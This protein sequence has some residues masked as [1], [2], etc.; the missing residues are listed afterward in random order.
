MKSLLDKI[1]RVLGDLNLL[2]Q[3]KKWDAGG[4][5]NKTIR[6]KKKEFACDFSQGLELQTL[7]TKIPPSWIKIPNKDG[8]WY[9]L[10]V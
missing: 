4:G 2:Q 10:K 6:K 3:G 9:V 5:I 8:P 1:L 7:S